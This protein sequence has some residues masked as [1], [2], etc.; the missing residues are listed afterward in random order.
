MRPLRH[1]PTR[2]PTSRPR[3]RARLAVDVSLVD[4]DRWWSV[5]EGARS[6]SAR[7]G[8]LLRELFARAGRSEAA[9]VLVSHSRLLR[10]LFRERASAAFAAT[11]LG[12]ALGVQFV[13]NCAVL[14]VV[15]AD[16]AGEA[17][18]RVAEA[19]FLFGSGFK[20]HR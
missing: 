5:G 2:P 19:Q 3:P 11:P 12:A 6:V 20:G 13:A 14:R 18:P 9:V 15:L 1:V 8:A 7:L 16:D 10:Q 17:P 4:R